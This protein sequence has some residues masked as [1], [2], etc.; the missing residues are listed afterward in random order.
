MS[1]SSSSSFSPAKLALAATGVLAAATVGY[2]VY[3]DYRRRNDAGFRRKLL[4]QHKKLEKTAKYQQEAGKEQ[5]QNALR[6][7]IALA[8][9]EKVT[10]ATVPETAEGKEQFFMEQVA[11]GEQLAA[12]S[13]EFYVASAISFYKALKELIMIYQKTQPPA[14]FDLVMELIS[15]EI[16]AAAS[17]ASARSSSASGTEPL[18]EEIDEKDR[19]EK[20]LDGGEEVEIKK[21]PSSENSFVHVEQETDAVVTP[22]GDVV[23]EAT[24]IEVDVEA[25]AAEIVEEKVEEVVEEAKAEAETEVEAE[26]VDP[27]EEPLAA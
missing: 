22:E 4:K 7:A 24:S 15:L 14:V 8:N 18:L 1:S 20:E 11:L 16:N 19:K 25:P 2:A 3:F 23:A 6:R 10:M 17:A 13:P 12:R 9:A 5:I 21:A 27:P 26:A